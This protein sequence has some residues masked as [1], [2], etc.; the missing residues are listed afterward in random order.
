[1][2]WKHR[3]GFFAAHCDCQHGRPNQ[4]TLEAGR[5]A[6]TPGPLRDRRR[7]HG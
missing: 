2:F 6:R 1:L 5:R 3:G 4:W 7:P